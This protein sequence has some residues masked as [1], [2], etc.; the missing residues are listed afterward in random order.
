[1]GKLFKI[2][3]VYSKHTMPAELIADDI[4]KMNDDEMPSTSGDEHNQSSNSSSGFFTL[5]TANGLKLL[6]AQ[7]QRTSTTEEKV[8]IPKKVIELPPGKLTKSD[9]NKITNPHPLRISSV[10]SGESVALMTNGLPIANDSDESN[11]Q[12]QITNVESLGPN[13]SIEFDKATANELN[14]NESTDF[15]RE[16]LLEPKTEPIDISDDEDM[17]NHEDISDGNSIATDTKKDDY[18]KGYIYCSTNIQL[19]KINIEWTSSTCIKLYL[20]KPIK[21][22]YNDFV[23]LIPGHQRNLSTVSKYLFE[24]IR[25]RF[26][27]VYPA[28]LKLDWIFISSDQIHEEAVSLCD[29]NELDPLSV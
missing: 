22:A 9:S 1:M 7:R 4:D 17:F 25:D 16:I 18:P 29:F 5:S 24:Y 13:A 19:G 28:H 23:H 15:D 11:D 10:L 6:N 14:D 8:Y 21:I 26:I 12:P 20:D 27:G 3:Q 2:G